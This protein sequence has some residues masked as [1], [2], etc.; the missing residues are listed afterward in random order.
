M[1]RQGYFMVLFF[2]YQLIITINTF[3]DQTTE[4]S[5]FQW[6]SMYY[7]CSFPLLF[8]LVRLTDRNFIKFLKWRFGFTKEKDHSNLENLSAF[9]NSSLNIELVYCILT[10]IL[11]IQS[12]GV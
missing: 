8:G 2:V 1:L 9:V 7:Y 4:I 10:G 6:V 12:S 5:F 11:K 3:L